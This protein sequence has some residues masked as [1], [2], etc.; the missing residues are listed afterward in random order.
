[1]GATTALTALMSGGA[2]VAFVVA[3]RWLGRGGDP[4]RAAGLGIVA[5]L[6]A[7]SMV[8]FA[9]PAASPSL[10]RA[11]VVLVGFGGG[12]FAVGTLTAAMAL[13]RDG[14]AGLA[15][16]AWGAVQASCAGLAI[17]AGGALRD[18]VGSLATAGAFGP[19]L[20][21]P[22]TGYAAVYHVELLLLFSTLIALGPL[23]RPTRRADPASPSRFGLPGLPG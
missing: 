22:A 14:Y 5:G 18:A 4:L 17:A 15:L 2:L 21:T 12:L 16:G 8:I 10:F 9:E 6:A 23:V 7:F 20:A 3:A 13:D 19:L 1:V 11:G